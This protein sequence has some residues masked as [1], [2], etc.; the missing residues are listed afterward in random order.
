MHE[1]G[2]G[3]F[4]L[5][6]L[7]EEFTLT[8]KLRS[9]GVVVLVEM[10]PI[11]MKSIS[12]QLL[13]KDGSVHEANTHIFSKSEPILVEFP[14]SRV[15]KAVTARVK[16]TALMDSQEN[17]G[18]GVKYLLVKGERP[19]I[20]KVNVS[21]KPPSYA[22]AREP[23]RKATDKLFG[24]RKKNKEETGE[25]AYEEQMR[26]ALE[27]SKREAEEKGHRFEDSSWHPHKE[28][29]NRGKEEQRAKDGR[30]KKEKEKEKDRDRE[31]ER[32]KERERERERRQ[33]KEW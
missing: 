24:E 6:E 11:N 14:A 2:A 26:L 13:A 12:F 16:L 21:R 3:G 19:L 15:N 7:I 5:N 28:E 23:P 29:E 30:S 17:G 31:R 10:S 22:D 18:T 4:V 8:L 32:E 20:Q 33:E 9:P 1:K 25:L 27:A